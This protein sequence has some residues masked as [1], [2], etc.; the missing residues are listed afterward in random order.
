MS[1]KTINL[2][3]ARKARERAEKRTRTESE[4]RTAA[5]PVKLARA[6]NDLEARRLDAHRRDD[7]D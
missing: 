1:G 5:A 7:K 4:T 6:E 2:R 3:R